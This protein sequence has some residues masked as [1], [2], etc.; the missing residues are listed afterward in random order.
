MKIHAIYVK[1]TRW[2]FLKSVQ[3]S[4]STLWVFLI[5]CALEYILKYFI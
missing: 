3:I 1:S 5:K 2:R 4:G